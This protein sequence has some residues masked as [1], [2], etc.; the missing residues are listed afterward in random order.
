MA[1][2]DDLRGP[3]GLPD[4]GEVVMV[5]TDGDGKRRRALTL[6][7]NV[8]QGKVPGKD[9]LLELI[10]FDLYGGVLS[11]TVDYDWRHILKRIRVRIVFSSKGM[12]LA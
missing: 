7:C 12:Q 11:V 1:A 6:L 3:D 8:Q 9:L 10:L 2:Y 5:A 4:L